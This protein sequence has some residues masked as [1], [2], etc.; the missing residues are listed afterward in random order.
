VPLTAAR[1]W[2]QSVRNPD[3]S[4]GYLPGQDGRAEPTLLVAAATGQADLDWLEATPMSW[5]AWLTPVALRHVQAAAGLRALCVTRILAHEGVKVEKTPGHDGLIPAWAW[6]EGTAPWI[7]PTCYAVLSLQ[8]EGRRDH[9][10]T[11]QGLA[12]LQD[13]QCRDGGWNYGNS[14]VLGQSLESFPGPTAWCVMALPPGDAVQRGLDRLDRVAERPSSTALALTILAR[15]AHDQPLAPWVA[16][17]V[18]RQQTDGSFGA[19]RIDRTA[20]AAA[21]LQVASG[22]PHPFA[23]A[24]AS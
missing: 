24:A 7:E 15:A 21:A 11:T 5:Q 12:M 1:R 14:E 23:T 10:R 9:T 22:G 6:V 3:G 20:L 19:G 16:S 2:L 13:R 18:S 4:W 17:L 8:A